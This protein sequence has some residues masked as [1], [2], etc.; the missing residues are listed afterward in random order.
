MRKEHR[1]RLKEEKRYSLQRDD[2]TGGRFFEKLEALKVEAKTVRSDVIRKHI[3]KDIE[4]LVKAVEFKN[5]SKTVYERMTK[6]QER[7]NKGK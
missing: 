4:K 6:I 5:Y 2:E 3:L 7:I 1:S